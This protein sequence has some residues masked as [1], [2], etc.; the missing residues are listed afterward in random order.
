MN[1]E[2]FKAGS[3]PEK[4]HPA[5]VKRAAGKGGISIRTL[6]RVRQIYREERVVLLHCRTQEQRPLPPDREFESGQEA[7]PFMVEA[8]GT[9]QHVVDIAVAIEHTERLALLQNLDAV[10]GHRR[11]GEDVKLVIPADDV[12]HCGFLRLCRTCGSS[13]PPPGRSQEARFQSRQDPIEDRTVPLST[14]RR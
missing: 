1:I 11:R 2:A 10:V 12:V 14:R 5:D 3:L 7:R 9:G 4:P 6:V 8:L 13:S